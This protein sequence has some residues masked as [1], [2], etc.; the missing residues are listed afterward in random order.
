M[1]AFSVVFT[2][3]TLAGLTIPFALIAGEAAVAVLAIASL[4]MSLVP[5]T[6]VQEERLT[7]RAPREAV[8][9]AIA[10]PRSAPR[11]TPE[12]VAVEHLAGEPGVVG[13]R[14]RTMLANGMV[15]TAEVVAAE[16]PV[17]LVIRSWHDPRWPRRAVVIET[18]RT[19]VATPAGT[20]LTIRMVM[21][22]VLWHRIIERLQHSQVAHRH[23]WSNERLRDELEADAKSHKAVP[24]S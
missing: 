11:R 2:I 19:L 10:D 12:V 14:W 8:Y 24:P 9:A 18:E 20:E 3:V 6:I 4:I 5:A 15:L 7:I 16:P 1:F 22:A 23:R 17:R 21:H 13:T